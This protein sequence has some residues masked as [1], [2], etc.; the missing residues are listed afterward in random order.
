VAGK[1]WSVAG[2]A[3]FAREAAMDMLLGG[4]GYRRPYPAGWDA[5]AELLTGD[6]ARHL[7]DADLYVISPQMCDVV[8]A[9]AQ[10]LTRDDLRLLAEEDLPSPSGLL[11]LP[12]PLLV[13]SVGGELGDDRAFGWHIPA[14][15]N[16]ADPMAPDRVRGLP[17]VRIS[18]YHDSHGPVRP[19]S[20]LEL[21][22]Q[23]PSP[24]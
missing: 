16:V 3:R 22:A 7:A 23:A 14:W 1:S 2:A 5:T 13:N 15:F 12:Y 20:F 9:A 19:D 17:A 21:A 10:S 24:P 6:D 4:L 8:V 18:V 11:V